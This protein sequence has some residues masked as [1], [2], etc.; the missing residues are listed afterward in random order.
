M[1][2]QEQDFEHAHWVDGRRAH[3]QT[4][5]LGES[6]TKVLEIDPRGHLCK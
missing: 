1:E 3:A 2:A 5:R 6:G 4:V